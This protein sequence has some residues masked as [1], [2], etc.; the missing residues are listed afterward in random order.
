[1]LIVVVFSVQ[2]A[3]IFR[4]GKMTVCITAAAGAPL[5][6]S[7]SAPGYSVLGTALQFLP[8][9]ASVLVHSLQA[10]GASAAAA[11]AIE[12]VWVLFLH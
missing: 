7:L 1:M 5:S 2:S 11:A 8:G 12:Q 10:I 6:G 4:P 9:G 3:E